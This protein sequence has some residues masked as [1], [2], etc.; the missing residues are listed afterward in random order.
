M[1]QRDECLNWVHGWDR[2]FT[3]PLFHCA[4]SVEQAVLQKTFDGMRFA[5]HQISR[6]SLSEITSPS[7]CYVLVEWV[8]LFSPILYV[9]DLHDLWVSVIVFFFA[10]F[11]S[12]LPTSQLSPYLTSMGS[13]SLHTYLV[14]LSTSLLFTCTA[15][16]FCCCFAKRKPIIQRVSTLV[17]KKRFV[18][19]GTLPTALVVSLIALFLVLPYLGRIVHQSFMEEYDSPVQK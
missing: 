1:L 3:F 5:M 18:T 14:P 13:E 12:I 6:K 17:G 7:S 15:F 2:K 16:W 10:L 19:N 11:Q 9:W 4:V 8:V